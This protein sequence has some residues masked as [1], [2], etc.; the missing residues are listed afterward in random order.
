[1]SRGYS[2]D[3]S[4][5]LVASSGGVGPLIPPSIPLLLYAVTASQSVA[6]LFVAGYVPGFLVG[7]TFMIYTYL[8]AKK[9]NYPAEPKPTVKSFFISL[10]RAIVPLMLPVII[11]GGILSGMFTATES[12]IA[13]VLYCFI[14]GC[15]VYRELKLKDMPDVILRAAKSTG[16]VLA[17][18]STASFLSYV[19][20]LAKIPQMV[21]SMMLGIT[22]N[23][24]LFLLMVNIVLIVAGMF[25]D[26]GSAIIILTPVFLPAAISV[27]VD[28]VFF[29]VMMTLN[30][31]IGVLTP[32]VGMNLYVTSSIAE[33]DLIRLSKAVIPFIFILFAIIVLIVVFPD[34]IMFLPNMMG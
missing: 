29:G 21:T 2:L 31:M 6:K 34:I 3:F 11:M 14:I 27:G 22:S 20:T 10:G 5:A 1:V 33:I 28:P 13:A 7:I 19:L 25:L 23:R 15:F 17:V 4:A 18:L 26:A 32:P 24:I 9:H 12:A 8:Y 16:M 30:L